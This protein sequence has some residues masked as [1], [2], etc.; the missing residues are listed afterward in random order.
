MTSQLAAAGHI[1]R[2]NRFYTQRMGLLNPGLLQSPFS[3]T[4]VRVLY[5]IA[6]LEAPTASAIAAALGL[7]AGYLSRLLRR[8]QQR[9]LVA[10]R[11]VPE[12]RRQRRLTLSARGKKAFEVLNARATAEI[13]ELLRDVPEGRQEDL[14]AS[15]STIEE[16]LGGANSP[17]IRPPELALRDP[18]PGD[19]GWVVERHGELYHEEYGWTADFERLVARIVGEFAAGQHPG[20]RCWIATLDG[21]RAGS[22][23]LMPD[24]PEIA[25]L[26]LLLVEPWA[27][28]HGLGTQLVNACIEAA[29]E[30]GY[31]TLTLW[32]N[33]VLH[34]ARRLYQRAGFRL[35]KSEPHQSFGHSLVGQTW[36][37]DL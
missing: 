4:E 18:E 12:D 22:V 35:V 28:G 7:D 19:L 11:A 25:R 13:A 2:F 31:R 10:A 36:E 8:L 20:Q 5:E 14:L 17:V 34:E 23:F 24:S 6:H 16:L 1:R 30:G 21:R 27:R 29:R 37:L 32:T 26:R 9:G 15:F 33:D 3:L